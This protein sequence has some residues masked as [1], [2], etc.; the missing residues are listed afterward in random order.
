M[1]TSPAADRPIILFDGVCNLCEGCVQ[2]VIRRDPA[3][4]FRFAPLQSDVGASLLAQ[5]DLEGDPLDG[6]VLVDD[7]RC[8]R[9][10]D[11]VIRIA[12]RLGLPYRLLAPA[13]VV[14]RP[15][16][17]LV[18]DAIANRRYDWFGKKDECMRPTPDIQDRFLAGAPG[19][20]HSES[21]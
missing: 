12:G 19:T 17:D 4:R 15:L 18:Y 7:G 9:K 14:P 11:A 5:C 20:P 10:S 3:G 8:Y 16:R 2:W 13:R 21:A 1:S 6:I